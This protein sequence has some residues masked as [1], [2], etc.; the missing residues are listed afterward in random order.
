M[1]AKTSWESITKDQAI[2]L[3]ATRGFDRDEV[4]AAMRH[5]ETGTGTAY[6]QHASDPLRSAR[7][8]NQ[9]AEEWDVALVV[10]FPQRAPK[11]TP[12]QFEAEQAN[13]ALVEMLAETFMAV[14]RARGPG[15]GFLR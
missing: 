2:K 1:S 7:I 6:A 4:R 9:G 13:V 8:T 12:E 10:R 3:L 15:H 11:V 14:C 5:T